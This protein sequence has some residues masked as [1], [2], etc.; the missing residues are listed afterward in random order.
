MKFTKIYLLILFI[1][2]FVNAQVV[3]GRV[4]SG[5]DNHPISF[6]KIGIAHIQDGTIA[7]EN[8]NYHLD[9]T[10]IDRHLNLNIEVGG[11]EVFTI[12][13]Y[14]FLQQDN[15]DIYLKEKVKEI[16]TVAIKSRKFKD[17]HWGIDSKSRKILYAVYPDRKK[18]KEEQSK[19]FAIKISNR[20]R[21]KLQKIN[22][23]IVEFETDV[24]VK[25]RVNVYDEKNGKP[26]Q[27]ILYQDITGII[28]KDSIIDGTYTL[29]VKKE[30]INVEG[31][32]FVSI[33]FLNYFKGHIFIS[34]GLLKSGYLRKYYGDWEKVSLVSPAINID[35]KVEK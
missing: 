5:Y 7:D 28:T 22:L 31:N 9:L 25:I 11:Y 35:V 17:K 16:E 3:S 20:K 15:H 30:H 21:V 32:F 13:I 2:T 27:S 33:Q 19:E 1:G 26:S 18:D 14:K 12:P 4:L 23:N 34:G 29:D 24:P 8:G 6:A 10:N